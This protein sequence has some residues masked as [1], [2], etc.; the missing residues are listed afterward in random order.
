MDTFTLDI[1]LA[2]NASSMPLT[3]ETAVELDSILSDAQRTN[4]S[5]YSFCVIC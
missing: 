5:I 3:E 4:A 2:P 1:V